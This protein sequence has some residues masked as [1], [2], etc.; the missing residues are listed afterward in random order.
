M[1][2]VTT[3]LIPNGSIY[4]PSF[5]PVKETIAVKGD[6]IGSSTVL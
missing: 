1:Q 2:Q 3:M 4:T 5:F 6:V